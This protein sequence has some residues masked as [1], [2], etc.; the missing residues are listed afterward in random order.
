M[1]EPIAPGQRGLYADGIAALEAVYPEEIRAD[2]DDIREMISRPGSV[3]SAA[4]TDGTV[5][6]AVFGFPLD[7]DQIAEY[8]LAGTYRDGDIYLESITVDASLRG[9]GVGF[10]LISS[11]ADEARAAGYRRIVGHFRKNG[12]LLLIRKIGGIEVLTEHDWCGTGEDFVC[13]VC[14]LNA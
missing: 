11:F 1:I 12:S 3:V 8:R 10:K 7:E 2:G 5:T 6:G 14:A 9:Q 4:L 13:C